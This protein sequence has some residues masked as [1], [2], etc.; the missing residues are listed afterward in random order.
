MTIDNVRRVRTL[1]GLLV[2]P[3]GVHEAL[4][5][6]LVSERLLVISLVA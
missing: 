3:S 5:H 4:A 2:M 6:Q 1:T